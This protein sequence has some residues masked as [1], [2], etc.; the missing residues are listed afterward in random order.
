MIK[1]GKALDIC[2]SDIYHQGNLP[3]QKEIYENLNTYEI[4]KIL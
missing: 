1:R 3:F 2:S 4:F